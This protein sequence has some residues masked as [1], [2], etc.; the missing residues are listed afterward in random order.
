VWEE[1]WKGGEKGRGEKY[2]FEIL[3]MLVLHSPS[4]EKGKKGPRGKPFSVNL[5]GGGSFAGENG[6]GR[7]PTFADRC[8]GKR[9]LTGGQAAQV[10][11]S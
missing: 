9:G 11:F 10:N 3:E 6:K 2:T 8:W 7:P 1:E 5:K 4:K